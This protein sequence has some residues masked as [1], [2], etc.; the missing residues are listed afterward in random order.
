MKILQA[1]KVRLSKQRQVLDGLADKLV[2]PESAGKN[3]VGFVEMYGTQTAAL[4]DSLHGLEQDIA[5]L[6]E[7]MEA[8]RRNLQQMNVTT[9]MN[10][11]R[12]LCVLL[13]VNKD[14]DIQLKISYVVSKAMWSPKYDLRV[15]SKDGQMKQTT[16]EDWT[17]TRLIL[18]TAMPSVGGNIPELDS[19]KLGF[20]PR[21]PKVS[22]SNSF[23]RKAPAQMAKM[24]QAITKKRAA[25]AVELVE[26]A[27]FAGQESYEESDE[28]EALPMASPMA[29]NQ[30]QVKENV[31]STMYEIPRIATIPCDNVG[32]KVSVAIVNL[33]P[34]FQHECVPKKSSHAFLRAHVKNTSPY[35]LLAGPSNIFLDNNF[36]AKAVS[37]SEEFDCSLGVDPAVKVVYKPVHKFREQSG[38][39]AKH[40]TFTYRQEIELKNTR[41]DDITVHVVDQLPQSMEEKIKPDVK[42]ADKHSVAKPVRLT[43]QN[44]IEWEASIGPGETKELV[45]KYSVEY[46]AGEEIL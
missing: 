36:I 41:Q 28:F 30:A 6:Q 32:H 17:D 11:T 39:M 46:P 20:K 34:T 16:G 19:W 2:T 26:D 10:E 43:A 31:T 25:P 23:L 35:A 7:S 33:E 21:Q 14:T 8:I 3:M 4:D 5:R 1:K 38:F 40:V 44:N 42:P 18:S 15:F 37:P 27:M 22:K 29:S 13:D 24:R 12:V 45:L 9:V